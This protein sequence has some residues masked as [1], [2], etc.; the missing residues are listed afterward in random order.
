MAEPDPTVGPDSA[1][2]GERKIHELGRVVESGVERVRRLQHE[3]HVLAQEQIE[4]LARD[5]DAMSLRTN[6]I[7]EGGDAYP[8]GVRE[9][10]SRMTDELALQAKT[11]LAIMERAPKY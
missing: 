10:C 7:A 1:G 3:T 5:M 4:I 9:L 8:V 2:G 6:E 11:L